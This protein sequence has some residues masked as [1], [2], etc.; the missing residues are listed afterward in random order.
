[1]AGEAKALEALKAMLEK[2]IGS[3]GG[4]ES[5]SKAVAAGLQKMPK[6]EIKLSGLVAAYMGAVKKTDGLTSVRPAT[7]K[8]VQDAEKTP[9]SASVGKAR[10]ELSKHVADVKKA[11]GK[12]KKFAKFEA[13]VGSIEGQLTKML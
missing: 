7:L 8:A 4:L 11:S 6:P 10:D 5:K 12:D 3:T 2:A 9:S 13:G 1:M